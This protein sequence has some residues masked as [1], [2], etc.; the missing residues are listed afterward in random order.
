MLIYDNDI[1]Q[2]KIN[3]W[4][5][6]KIELQNIKLTFSVPGF[7]SDLSFVTAAG[8]YKNVTVRVKKNISYLLT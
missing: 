8:V 1:K 5:K 6:D 4:T 2:K 7:K 3:I